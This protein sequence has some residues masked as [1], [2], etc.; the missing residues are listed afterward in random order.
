MYHIKRP[1]RIKFKP[2]CYLHPLYPIHISPLRVAEVDPTPQCLV[3]TNILGIGLIGLG[4]EERFA[5]ISPDSS[6][7]EILIRFIYVT[8]S[9]VL[10][11]TL[12]IGDCDGPNKV[13][14]HC[15][16]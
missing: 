11:N 3:G 1:I 9:N 5:I 15:D 14:H 8:A 6:S 12:F 4:V 2:M 16:I 13:V 7:F 10:S